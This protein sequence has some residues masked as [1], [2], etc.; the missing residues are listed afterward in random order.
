M[1]YNTVL[2]FEALGENPKHDHSWSNESQREVLFS[3]VI[4][5]VYFVLQI[6][7]KEITFDGR[8]WSLCLPIFLTQA[9][10]VGIHPSYW[11]SVYLDVACED[12]LC[13]CRPRH[14]LLRSSCY[15]PVKVKRA[16]LL[17]CYWLRMQMCYHLQEC[18]I[19]LVMCSVSQLQCQCLVPSPD[20]PSGLLVQKLQWCLQIHH[21]LWRLNMILFDQVSQTQETQEKQ[22][23]AVF[24]PS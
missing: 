18:L 22:D 13:F 8:R 15:H 23:H 11:N 19:H 7:K 20:F 14:S 6:T 21:Y 1:L 4:A 24:Q 10:T 2:T 12:L 17:E 16:Y 5:T 3:V 9:R